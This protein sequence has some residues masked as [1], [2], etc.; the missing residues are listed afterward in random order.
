VEPSLFSRRAWLLSAAAAIGCG[1]P[2][3]TGYAGYCFVANQQ[4]RSLAVV[5]L[6]SFRLLPAIRLDAAPSAVVAHP[7]HPKAF[8]LAPQAGAIYEIDAVSRSVSRRVRA[9]NQ[10]VAIRLAPSGDVL[11]VLMRDPAA[12]VEIPLDSFRPRRRIRLAVPPDDFDL[13]SDGHAAV[14]SQAARSVTV[15]FLQKAVVEQTAPAAVELTAVRFRSDG[16]QVLAASGPDRSIT[17]FEVATGKALVRLPLPVEPRYFC[18]D[19]AGGQ[20]FVTGDG[21]DAVVIL[22]P[23]STEI[24]ETVLAG[25]APAG[26]AVQD[27]YL[28]V[29]NPTANTVTVLD[30]DD[31]RLASVIQVGLEPRQILITPDKQYALVLNEK[32]GDLAVIR[33]YSLTESVARRYKSAAL[34]TLIPVGEKPVSAAVVSL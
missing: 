1:P 11:W 21:M 16:K 15:V 19:S 28:F 18:Y 22:Y 10:A 8:V 17:I 20:L 3:A 5:D 23:Y 2:K 29:A 4:S 31:R 25:R 27:S 7:A 30:I 33:F 13:S 14:V 34:F 12:L 6:N 26:M 9:G 24:A 32:S